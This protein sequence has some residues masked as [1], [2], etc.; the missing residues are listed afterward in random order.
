MATI[1][2]YVFFD[3]EMLCSNKGMP[4]EDMESI[5][6]GAVK[7]DLTT[8]KIHFFDRFIKPQHF[9]GLSSFCKELTGINNSDIENATSFKEVMEDFLYWVDGIKKTRFFSWSKSDLLRLKS[10]GDRYNLPSSILKKIEDRY[11]DFQ[12][13]FTKRVSFGNVS[14]ENA[15]KL[16]NLSFI[17][18]P[19]EPMYDSLNTLRV[20]LCFMENLIQSDLVM[21]NQFIFLDNKV[22][23]MHKV[24]KRL[25]FNIKRDITTLSSEIQ[26]IIKLKNIKKILK[27]VDK[28]IFKY[29]NILLN[30][31]G[32]FNEEVIRNVKSLVAFRDELI[33]SYN[34]HVKHNAKIMILHEHMMLPVHNPKVRE[35]I[36][37]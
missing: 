25:L 7:L 21:V 11:V 1:K 32:I 14:V 16:Y 2:Q 30:R 17:G 26:P 10:D 27:K 36:S 9:S 18:N 12:A 34:M 20:Y 8:R 31:S 6:I 33:Y 15:L 19:H 13:V 37:R 24:N 4:F 35:L 23:S 28:L 22:P 3:F 5:R 29:H